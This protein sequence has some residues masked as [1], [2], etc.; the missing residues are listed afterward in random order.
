[1][2]ERPYQLLPPLSDEQRHLLR[3]SIKESGVLEPVVFD[4]NG[5]ILDGHHR[6]EIAEELGIDYP[7]RVMKGL[8]EA[9]KQTYALTVN[10]ARRQ[11]T[12]SE[13]GSLV[14]QLRSRGMSIRAIAKATGINRETVR[15]D[16]SGD[17]SVSPAEITGTDGKS[18]A[19]SKPRP[20]AEE[21]TAGPDRLRWTCF[22][23]EHQ[24][25][26]A[27]GESTCPKC[28][29]FGTNCQVVTDA[30]PEDLPACPPEEGRSAGLP[31]ALSGADESD[32]SVVGD[33]A[34]DELPDPL[35][36][37]GDEYRQ[38][39]AE[40]IAA[41][42]EIAP[43]FVRPAE[44]DPVAL[45]NAAL[46]QFVPDQNAGTFAWRKDLHAK[47]KPAHHLTLWIDIDDAAEFASADDLETIRHLANSFADLHRR[48]LA[49]RNEN[50]VPL[51]AVR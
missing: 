28:G 8:D 45:V 47:L 42:A 21:R 9:D 1:M 11:L 25:E 46:D 18:Y 43:E 15:R 29:G 17:T 20:V 34:A 31:S 37:V 50:V 39:P 4:E 14:A 7:R 2:T 12:Q 49:A 32:A 48:I 22:G 16:L 24:F 6:V 23:C 35:A 27:T 44:P 30:A 5:E 19:S 13:R 26:G 40:R 33:V 3:R 36:G 51:R 38:D 41:V 10:V